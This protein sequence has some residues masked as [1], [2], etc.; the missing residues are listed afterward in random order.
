M[1][2]EGLSFC[3]VT[4]QSDVVY[5]AVFVDLCVLDC[6]YILDAYM[7]NVQKAKEKL[8]FLVHSF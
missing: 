7:Q 3:S 1:A 4:L 2:L 8:V 6:F 5:F